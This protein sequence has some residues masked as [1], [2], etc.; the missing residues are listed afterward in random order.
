MEARTTIQ[1]FDWR[2]LVLARKLAPEIALVALTD[3]QPDEDTMEIGKPGASIWLG[4]S[5]STITAVRCRGRQGAGRE[6]LVAAC[7]RP[8]AGAGRR[9][10]SARPRGRPLDRQRSEGHGD[11]ARAR[12]RRPD[13]DYPDRL[14]AVL[15]SKGIAVPSP[16][17]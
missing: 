7:A 17:R 14:R 11:R 5:T 2:T 3:Q 9:G 4:G 12:H 13:H 1:S 10:A 15:E 8:H 6:G 16:T